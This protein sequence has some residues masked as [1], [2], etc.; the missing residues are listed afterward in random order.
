MDELRRMRRAQPSAL[1]GEGVVLLEVE[2][3]G[4]GVKTG[5]KR[6]ASSGKGMVASGLGW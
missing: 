1:L 4:V 2:G 6:A 3:F 5:S